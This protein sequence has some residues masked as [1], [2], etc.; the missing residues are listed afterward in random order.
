ML[1]DAGLTREEASG[2]ALWIGPALVFGRIATG[3]LFDIL[4]T[5]LVA[6]CAFS[7][8]GIACFMLWSLPITPVSGPLI[9][10]V[11][12]LSLGSEI[13]VVAYLSSRYFGLRRYGLI[14]GI[15]ISVYSLAV[16]ISAWLTGRSYD[17]SGSYDTA[18]LI[19]AFGVGTAIVLIFSL[20]EPPRTEPE[21]RT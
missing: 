19:L 3:L 1:T 13:D 11:I 21:V 2:V 12:G 14:Y 17:A 4:P 10:L 5:R 9:A 15:L 16:G 20:G 6:A 7:I 18:L 8:P